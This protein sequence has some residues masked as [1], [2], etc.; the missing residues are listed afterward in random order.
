[1]IYQ[2]YDELC[3]KTMQMPPNTDLLSFTQLY[4][5]FGIECKIEGPD[6]VEGDQGYLIVLLANDSWISL[7]E[8]TMDKRITGYNGFHT[9]IMFDKNGKFE[10][11]EIVE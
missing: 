1:M 10:E 11:Q 2:N 4:K 9:R 8:A 6:E 5:R 3:R 7:D